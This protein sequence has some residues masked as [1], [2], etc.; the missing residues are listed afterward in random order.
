MSYFSHVIPVLKQTKP[1]YVLSHIYAH[2][3]TYE[4]IDI[5]IHRY[6]EIFLHLA[7]PPLLVTL[8]RTF[9]SYWIIEIQR[10]YLVGWAVSF[11]ELMMMA[12]S[13]ALKRIVRLSLAQLE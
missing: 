12:R 3:G 8:W 13:T 7:V 5:C 4:D 2:R 9:L 10:D 6:L 11:D 1:S